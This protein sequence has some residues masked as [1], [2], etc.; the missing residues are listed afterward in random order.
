MTKDELLQMIAAHLTVPG[1]VA[2]PPETA[3]SVLCW[4]HL[5]ERE[6]EV[7]TCLAAGLTH[8]EIAALQCVAHGT[9]RTHAGNIISALQSVN[10][11]GAAVYG[12]LSGRV[13]QADVLALLRRYR[14][15]LFVQ[16]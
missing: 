8:Q 14:P 10:A 3:A 11:R 4:P 6:L 5:T 13:A 1:D 7:L 9:V 15:Q 12:L 2:M 16:G